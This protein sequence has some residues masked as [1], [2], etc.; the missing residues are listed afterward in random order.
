M[1]DIGRLSYQ[2]LL[3][4]ED[5]TQLDITEAVQEL[6]WE[7][8]RNELATRITCTMVNVQTERGYLSGLVKLNSVLA[9][10]ASWGESSAEVARGFVYDWSHTATSA[11][12]EFTVTAYDPIYNLQESQDNRYITAGTGTKSAILSIC[13][14]W[15]IPVDYQ[16]PDIS[17]AKT[18]FRGEYLGDM[19]LELLDDA[20][21]KGGA[22]CVVRCDSGKLVILPRGSNAEI[23]HFDEDVTIQAKEKNSIASMVT[24]VKVVGK[25][26]SE[27]RRP[28]EAVINGK[29]E[30]GVRQ[31]IY[32]R[33]G[34]DSLDA[35]TT[36]AKEILAKDGEPTRNV[37]IQAPD[38]P[39]IRKGDL[40]HVASGSVSGYYL[41]DSIRHDAASRKMNLE[42]SAAPDQ[43][44][45]AESEGNRQSGDVFE[46][47]DRVELNGAVYR[48]SYGN[49]K[50]RTFK[51]YVGS[52]TLKVD[53]SR[54]CPYHVDTLGWVY[55]DT[56]RHI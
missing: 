36:A 28:V 53:T 26:D 34:D 11:A 45:D 8:G 10:I 25:E 15:E 30:F 7:E 12:L 37:T 52:I 39:T 35:A 17:H 46:K 22:K 48:D 55:P 21:K 38:V 1:I 44:T 19:I 20:A 2:L 3:I 33:D 13:E 31:R 54:A 40:V 5:G 18:V 16:G 29:T 23:Y 4:E 50:G 43:E 42:L 27:G 6:E 47:G 32:N 56:I 14:D 41:V 49:G 24:R 51:G 9:V